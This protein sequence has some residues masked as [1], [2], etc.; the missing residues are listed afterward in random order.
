MPE[1]WIQCKQ[2]Y[3]SSGDELGEIFLTGRNRAVSVIPNEEAESWCCFLRT[4]R[5]SWPRWPHTPSA[6]DTSWKVYNAPP[7]LRPT[8]Y[9]RLLAR[10]GVRYYTTPFLTIP[11]VRWSIQLT[12][13]TLRFMSDG[14]MSSVIKQ[15][16]TSVTQESIAGDYSYIIA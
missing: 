8:V 1:T 9:I 2:R 4:Y 16:N 7:S 6:L 3:N 11:R 5:F 10:I 14:V 13:I 12:N 15:I